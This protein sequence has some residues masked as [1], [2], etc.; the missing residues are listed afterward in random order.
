MKSIGSL[1]L[2]VMTWG[3][4]GCEKF[5]DE[6]SDKQLI[7]P[8][9][10]GDLQS[11]IDDFS[12]VNSSDP[13]VGELASDD[14]YLTDDVWAARKEED[15]RAYIWEPDYSVT[16][17]TWFTSYRTVYYTNIILEQLGKIERG[18]DN[19]REWDNVKGQAHFL[20]ARNF[21]QVAAIWSLAYDPNTASED[22]GIPLRLSSDF[23]IP[24][25]RSS[26]KETYEQIV[27]D[28]EQAISLLPVIP[29]HV[30][31]PSKPAAHALLA[32]AYLFMGDYENCFL[33]ADASLGMKSDLMDYSVLDG[34]KTYPIPLFNEEI[35]YYSVAAPATNPTINVNNANVDTVLYSWYDDGDLRKDL[36]FSENANGTHRIRGN[37]SGNSSRFFGLAVDEVYLMRA[38]CHTRAGNI[39]DALKDVNHLLAHRYRDDQQIGITDQQELLAY[40]LRERR[41]ELLFRG[42]R[43]PDVKR[44]NKEN[45]NIEFKRILNGQEYVLPPNDLRFALSIPEGVI[46]RGP[47]IVQNPR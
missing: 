3:L 17:T 32:R 16:E 36:F 1:L 8:S 10:L 15:Q 34:G 38:E 21:L 41:K 43:F 18:S 27:A 2:L 31:R 39:A 20:R 35:L 45:G 9:S 33:H 25:K 46:E 42:I 24:S 23:N 5:L 7:V 40:I 12:S 47:L 44:Q 30:L 37:Y 28:L 4:S 26:V 13:G 29:R 14:Y 22:L 19:Q 11:L 6:K